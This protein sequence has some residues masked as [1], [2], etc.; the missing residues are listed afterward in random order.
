MFLVLP[1]LYHTWSAPS[2]QI[3]ILTIILFTEVIRDAGSLL[4]ILVPYYALD[5]KAM[6]SA[7]VM[8]RR[9]LA[10]YIVHFEFKA[11]SSGYVQS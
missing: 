2:L 1:A 5:C 6:V 4:V 8:S 10:S 9:S 11:P 7:G 3:A